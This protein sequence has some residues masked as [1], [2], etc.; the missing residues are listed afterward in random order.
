MEILSHRS[1]FSGEGDR[2]NSVGASPR[3][4]FQRVGNYSKRAKLGSGGIPKSRGEA[5]PSTF[6]G[7][8]GQRPRISL[9]STQ[10]DS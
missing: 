9:F 4:F 8:F 3:L 6:H 5:F 10:L 7:P 2:K 1:D